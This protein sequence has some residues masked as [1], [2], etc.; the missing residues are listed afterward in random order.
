MEQVTAAPSRTTAKVYSPAAAGVKPA[1]AEDGVPRCT[2]VSRAS[3]G[4]PSPAR[5]CRPRATSSSR[6]AA[7]I[8]RGSPAS[9]VNGA[10]R[11]PMAGSSASGQ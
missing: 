3:A 7:K 4:A 2:R 6:V 9:G 11:R 1:T 8:R 10:T 5:T